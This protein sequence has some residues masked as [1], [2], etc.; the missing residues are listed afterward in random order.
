MVKPNKYVLIVENN[1]NGLKLNESNVIDNKGNKEYRLSGIFTEFNV[2]NRN[3]RIYTADKFLPHLNELVE[4]K[5]SLGAVYGEFD[6]LDVFDTSLQRI[7]H[8]IESITYNKQFN[9]VDGE[10]R[11]LNTHWGKEAKALVE[12]NCP[13]FVSSRAAGI[14]ESDG[15]VTV[16]KLFTY[17][18]VAD[19]GFGSARMEVKTLNESL[20]FKEKETNFR[21]YDVSDESK[22]NELFSMNQNDYVTKTQMDEYSDYLKGEISKVSSLLTE[23]VKDGKIDP[24]QIM[25]ITETYEILLE[26]QNKV[27]KYL[28]YLAESIQVVV[29]DNKSLTETTEKLSKHN[30]YLAENLEK[31]IKYSEYL[32]E[33]LDKNINYS[34]YIAETLDKNIDFSEYIAEHVNKNIQFSDYLAENVEKS[35]DY[36]E[37][38]AE[39]LDKNI[40]YSEYI[41]EN[42]DKNIEYSEYIA[43]N[44]DSTIA[45]SEYLAENLDNNIAYSEYIAEHVDNNIAYAEYIAEHVDNNIA[46][47][48]YI[49]ENVSDSQ[50][51]MNYIAEAVDNT[52]EVIKENKLF[53]DAGQTQVPNMRQIQDVDKY[54][55]DDDDFVQKPV[56]SQVQVQTPEGDVVQGEI[57]QEPVQGEEIQG[58]VQEPIQGEMIPD[59]TEGGMVQ[60]PIVGEEMPLDATQIPGQEEM[61][62]VQGEPVG[63]QVQLVPG[64]TVSIEDRTGEVL[65]SNPTN[66]ILVV[67]MTDNNELV[68]VHES[69][70][71]LIGDEIME[72]EDSLK[73]Y[74]NNLITETKKRKASETKDPHFVQFLTEKNKKAWI[75]L[76]AED[77]EKVIFAIN[78]SKEQV[79][80]ESQLLHAIQNALSV[81]KTF[82]DVLLENLPS[83]L[84]PIWKS[85]NENYKKSILSSAK[86]Y[87]SLNTPTRMEKFWESRRLE[88]YT[89]INESKKV[90]NESRVVDNTTLSDEQIDQFISKIKNI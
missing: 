59:E 72:T 84:E 53:E 83:D 55:E 90:L 22:I 63:A 76:S 32:A 70:V 5:N 51:Y 42:L 29:N 75:D 50:A 74:I 41:A 13:L 73:S 31:S 25:K 27:A 4:R 37:Y 58:E 77:K 12:D 46:Y 24:A 23:S 47:S 7:S 78:E 14:T 56:Q 11:L 16:K 18:A 87:P 30:D 9:R 33:Q 38:I 57:V 48:E 43:E 44:L 6:H 79:Y 62:S 15:T 89:Q 54:Y 36:S 61:P 60:E 3:E 64:A 35:I 1:T 26:Q 45:Y 49:A 10:I 88:S 17:D 86:L 52:L 68:E 39:N 28:D 21:I 66:N 85:L 69:K 8:T 19:P 65:A 71:T 80:S 2:M 34:E 82:D 40:A 81:Q 67:K 20:G